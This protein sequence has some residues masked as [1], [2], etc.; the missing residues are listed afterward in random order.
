MFTLGFQILFM[1]V[2]YRMMRGPF[3]I[4]AVHEYGHDFLRKYLIS[5]T[6]K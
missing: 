5:I 3:D 1:G 6:T 4:V 2:G